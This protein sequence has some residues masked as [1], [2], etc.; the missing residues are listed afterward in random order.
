MPS[1]SNNQV[2][3]CKAFEPISQ[4]YSQKKLILE[5]LPDVDWT[6]TDQYAKESSNLPT[7]GSTHPCSCVYPGSGCLFMEKA[8]PPR[9]LFFL[10][11]SGAPLKNKKEFI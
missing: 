10:F 5:A 6:L 1:D 2:M 3:G 11:F 4:R 8:T 9:Y 7:F